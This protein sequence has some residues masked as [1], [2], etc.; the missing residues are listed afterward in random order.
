MI[1]QTISHCRITAKLGSGGMGE[2]YL[3]EDS[4]PDRK[5]AL[6]F[7][8]SPMSAQPDAK[9]RFLP[10]TGGP[11]RQRSLGGGETCLSRIWID[12]PCETNDVVSYFV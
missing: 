8:P 3:A 4:K 9:A 5:V 1:D 7:L 11:S 12:P 10:E 2:V 6:K